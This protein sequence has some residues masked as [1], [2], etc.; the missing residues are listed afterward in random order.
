MVYKAG[1]VSYVSSYPLCDICNEY[2]R[3]DAKTGFHGR[4]AYLC[5]T[6]MRIYGP[7]QLGI[8]RGQKLVLQ[9]P[10]SLQKNLLPEEEF[11]S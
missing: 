8:G 5:P 9:K 10:D 2:A 3:Y 4:W 1:T 11:P 6:C 7:R